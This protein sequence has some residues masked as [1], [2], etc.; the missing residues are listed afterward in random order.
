MNF[1]CFEGSFTRCSHQESEPSSP[2]HNF[3][4]PS[5]VP[6][7]RNGIISYLYVIEAGVLLTKAASHVV[8]IRG[9]RTIITLFVTNTISLFRQQ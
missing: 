1:Q 8:L 7:L 9:V 5:V 3:P 2:T 6:L 4:I